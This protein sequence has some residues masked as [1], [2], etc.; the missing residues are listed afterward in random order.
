MKPRTGDDAEDGGLLL[1]GLGSQQVD[2]F[3]SWS[4]RSGGAS[5]FRRERRNAV[6]YQRP[7]LDPPGGGGG[8][9]GGKN[10]RAK[11]V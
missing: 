4:L 3:S 1:G 7:P 8:G 9:G 11:P 6:L 5:V 10:P 2:S